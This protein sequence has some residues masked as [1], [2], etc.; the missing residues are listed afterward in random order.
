MGGSIGRHSGL[1]TQHSA[2]SPVPQTPN[3]AHA[4]PRR[5]LAG[6]AAALGAVV[7]WGLT[8]VPGKI[9]LAEMGPFTLAVLRFCVA[10]AVLLPILPRS[11]L[12][13]RYLRTLPWRALAALG[14]TGVALYFGFQNLGLARTSATEAGLVSGSVPAVTA[15]M[16]ALLLRE[17]L[18]PSRVAG[19]AGSMAGV[20]IMVLG[21][22]S[23]GG[24]SLA[25]DLLMLASAVAWA[26]YTL[27][28]KGMGGKVPEALIL[29][30]T[31]A[32]GV[33]FL[34]PAAALEVATG[35]LGVVST[36]GW[37]SLLFLGV[38]G[39]AGAFFCWNAALRH[40]DASEAST[41]INLVPLVTVL[42]AGLMLGERPSL[43]QILG[44]ALVI[45]GVYLAGRGPAPQ[46]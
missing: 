23:A 31:M 39:S 5:R 37:L 32:F 38:A 8:F 7:I 14:F 1:S 29:V 2:P 22:A 46:D 6:I 15:A 21:N 26:S 35:G 30:S 36:S 10:L 25:G 12:R 9:A 43:P 40:L 27:L 11:Y 45:A 3:A 17:R 42:S 34:A 16:S 4:A 20:A 19:I 28:N 44:G 24:G 18:R 41:Y 33:L 13:P